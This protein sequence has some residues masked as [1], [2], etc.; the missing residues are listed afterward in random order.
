[1]KRSEKTHATLDRRHAAAKSRKAMSVLRDFVVSGEAD[2]LDIGTGSG[3][4]AHEL[5]RHFPSVTSV[6]VDDE[7]IVSGSYRFVRVRDAVLPFADRSFDVV[8][9]NHVIEH[10]PEQRE[11]LREVHRVLRD[12]GVCYLATPNR[13]WFIETHF[14]LPL[15]SWLPA[16]FA[17]VVTRIVRGRE[18]DIHPLS[19]RKLRDLARDFEVIDVASE[20]IRD[21]ERYRL[22]VMKL[23]QPLVRR[24]PGPVLRMLRFLYPTFIVILRKR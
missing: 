8:L 9:S 15:L 5:S 23:I 14:R 17:N 4:I 7:R 6:D 10:M 24:L 22:D 2:L 20:V 1:M 16:P 11:H 21:P 12:G 19:F 13:Y 18:Y 3:A